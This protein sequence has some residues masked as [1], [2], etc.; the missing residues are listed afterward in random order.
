MYAPELPS[1][2]TRVRTGGMP[3]RRAAL[4]PTEP[5]TAVPKPNILFFLA[6]DIG[7]V[8]KP[9][10]A[11]STL[12]APH[13]ADLAQQGMTFTKAYSD[14]ALC[15]PSRYAALTGNHAHRSTRTL[16]VWGMGEESAVRDGQQTLGIMLQAQ[17]YSTYFAGKWHLGGGT[18]DP[19]DFKRLTGG[20]LDHGFND[21]RILWLGLG[22]RP[23]VL[24][25]SDRVSPSAEANDVT[26]SEMLTWENWPDYS[27][28]LHDMPD[29]DEPSPD[30][31]SPTSW[32]RR[33]TRGRSHTLASST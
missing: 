28:C 18:R 20:P 31:W 4:Q 8:Y 29:V 25:D 6:D 15:A 32:P 27:P 13:I 30:G 7:P 9:W 16:G 22:K 21:S 14:C 12:D 3:S 5:A 19:N 33:N 2:C 10:N 1:D 17:G 24:F 11:D 23:F 26:R